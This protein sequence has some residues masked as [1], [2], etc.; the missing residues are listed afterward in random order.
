MFQKKL[1]ALSPESV[2]YQAAHVFLQ[3][4]SLLATIGFTAIFTGILRKAQERSLSFRD[5]GTALAAVAAIII[6]KFLSA[7][8]QEYF[9]FKSS[10]TVKAT[11]RNR[12]FSK[13]R[14]L[15]ASY[16]ERISSAEVVQL[17]GE[18]VDQ[19]E[20]YFGAYIPQLFYSILAPLTLF[21]F[22]TPVDALCAAVLF[23]CV[24]LIPL[25]IALV[26]TFAKR[27]L[28]KY[29]GQ[30]GDLGNTFLE[31]LQGMTTLKIYRTDGLRN[32]VMNQEAE[33]FRRITMKVLT[34]QLNSIFVMD[35]IAYGGAGT[36]I[37]LALLRLQSG[38][39]DFSGCFMFILLS[40]DFFIPMRRLGSFFHIAMNGIAAGEKILRLLGLPEP[41]E[42]TEPGTA[43]AGARISAEGLFFSYDGKRT[44]LKNVAFTVDGGSLTAI[45]G[46]SGSGKS[47]IAALLAGR[48][49]GYDGSITVR[50]CELSSIKETE[51][52]KNTV[53]TGAES[54]LFKGTV[55]DNLRAVRPGATEEELW[56]ALEKVR[57]AAFFREA[58]GLQTKLTEGASNLSGGQRQR[59]ALARALLFDGAVYIF[60]EASSNIDAESEKEIIDCIYRIAGQKTVV[61]ITHRLA[62]AERAGNIL[63][64]NNGCVAESGTH[65]E[66][67][68]A[69][70]YYRRL[71]DAQQKLEQVN[72]SGGGA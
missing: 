24:P 19:L 40:A 45:V 66:L 63:V 33:K 9:S 65:R 44:V 4:I 28:S 31:N 47:T 5:T 13:L 16:K 54:Y 70:G 32:E 6:I 55:Q 22:F 15:G 26:Q 50:G 37:I 7:I 36:G 17:T 57:I 25:T 35:F 2:K 41:E 18:G 59:L 60:D 56:E 48:I 39:L 49:R 46:E 51:L 20:T 61:L 52:L 11:L 43:F 23:V 67:Y 68:D 30:Y 10:E 3:W 8:F 29:W 71:W 69:G 12:I 53:Y 27:L 21:V 1:S 42:G 64:M 34:M 14:R 58:E 62:N 38:A 72:R